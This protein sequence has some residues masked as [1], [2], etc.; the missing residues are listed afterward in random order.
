MGQRRGGIGWAKIYCDFDQGSSIQVMRLQPQ[1]LAICCIWINGLSYGTF[2]DQE[3]RHV[4]ST[5]RCF[6]IDLLAKI[7]LFLIGVILIGENEALGNAGMMLHARS[8]VRSNY[9][10]PKKPQK[11]S[12]P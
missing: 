7:D 11:S 2:D 1:R 10:S 8:K 5:L 6:G 4:L 3:D 12:P 9:Q